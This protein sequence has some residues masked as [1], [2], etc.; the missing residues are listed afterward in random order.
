M[1]AGSRVQREDAE[2][3]KDRQRKK[4]DAERVA[5]LLEFDVEFEWRQQRRTEKDLTELRQRVTRP[6]KKTDMND[7]TTAD[8][9]TR[10]AQSPRRERLEEILDGSLRLVFSWGT[11]QPSNR[12][13]HLEQPQRPHKRQPVT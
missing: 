3:E 4:A 13:L 5:K 2:K 10:D 8:S 12:L 9:E 11:L 6:S 1:T 7:G